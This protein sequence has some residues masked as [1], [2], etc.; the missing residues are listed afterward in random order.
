MTGIRILSTD[1][2]GTLI[3]HGSDGRCSA[4]LAAVLAAFK[5]SG[6]LW[7]INTGRS[8]EHAI[9]GIEK[10][11]SPVTPDFVLTNEREIYRRS[12][13]GDWHDHGTW[14]NICHERH[15][16]LFEKSAP[17]LAA[18]EEL[19]LSSQDARIVY[20]GETPAGIVTVNEEAMDRMVDGIQKHGAK[21]PEFH[22]QRN[23][24]YL[25]FC[26]RDYHKGAA[27]GEL[28]RLEGID[29][30][31]VFAAG[32]HYNDISMLDGTY[33]AMTACPSNAIQEIKDVVVRS[34]GYVAGLA[35]GDGIAEA[36]E[37]FQKKGHGTEKPWPD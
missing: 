14:N 35:G 32:D 18:I 23:T 33:A 17:I 21:H 27:L 26:H 12:A 31:S 25:R 4:S 13:G 22:F 2:D 6:G 3:T 16:A 30:D 36:I 1:F 20:E 24:I 29:R 28:C 19:A 34:Q 9:E 7:A 5:S 10:F 8:L 15:R 11:H 37:Y